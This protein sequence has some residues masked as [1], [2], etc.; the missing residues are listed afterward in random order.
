MLELFEF[1]KKA[2]VFVCL[3]VLVFRSRIFYWG[4]PGEAKPEAE[5]GKCNLATRL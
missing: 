4:G 2:F 1:R 3:F 5:G